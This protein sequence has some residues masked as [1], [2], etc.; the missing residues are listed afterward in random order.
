MQKCKV[1]VEYIMKAYC[2]MKYQRTQPHM[3]MLK[4]VAT[5]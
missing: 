1:R 5:C 4:E 3:R 2:K